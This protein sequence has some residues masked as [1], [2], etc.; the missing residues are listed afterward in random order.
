MLADPLSL[1]EEGSE[2]LLSRWE[3]ATGRGQD[4]MM[5][6]VGREGRVTGACLLP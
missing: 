1:L 6:Q 2:T 4:L 3:A 5:V